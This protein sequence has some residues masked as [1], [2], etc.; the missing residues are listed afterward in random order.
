MS[1]LCLKCELYALRLKNKLSKKSLIISKK[2]Q[3]LVCLV[4]EK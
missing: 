4:K 2:Q 3:T 1:C